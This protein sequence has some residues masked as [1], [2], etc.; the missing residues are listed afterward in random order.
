MHALLVSFSSAMSSHT[1]TTMHM[2]THMALHHSTHLHVHRASCII[3][4]RMNNGRQDES[5]EPAEKSALLRTKVYLNVKVKTF[6]LFG[7]LKW[8]S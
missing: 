8:N 3:Q 6:S 1:Y 7:L 5:K 4:Q 2:Y